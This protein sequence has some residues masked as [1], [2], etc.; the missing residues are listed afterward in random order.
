MASLNFCDRVFQAIDDGNAKEL[1]KMRK[2]KEHTEIVNCLIQFNTDG[3][4]PL[5]LAIRKRNFDV[6]ESLIKSL[7]KYAKEESSSRLLCLSVI[8]QVINS[9]IPI[10]EKMEYLIGTE[11]NHLSWV[12]FVSDSV[13]NSSINRLEKIAALEL[14]GVAYVTLNRRD[15]QYY[16]G[17]QRG[18]ECWKQAM[19]LRH[20]AVDPII[21][22]ILNVQSADYVQKAF[23]GAVLVTT[24]EELEKMPKYLKICRRDCQVTI[25]AIL[26][27]LVNF[28]QLNP[29]QAAPYYLLQY[30]RSCCDPQSYSRAISTALLIIEQSKWCNPI[31]SSSRIFKIVIQSLELVATCFD[32]LRAEPRNSPEREEF[33][34]T[35]FLSTVKFFLL[36]E[37]LTRLPKFIHLK[38]MQRILMKNLFDYLLSS[39]IEWNPQLNQKETLQLKNYLTHCQQFRLYKIRKLYDLNYPYLSLL[40]LAVSRLTYQPRYYF[41]R[42]SPSYFRGCTDWDESFTKTKILRLVLETGADPNATDSSGRIPL[43]FVAANFMECKH[44]CRKSYWMFFQTLLDAGSNLYLAKSDG[45]TVLDVLR[46]R[47]FQRCG[48]PYYIDPDAIPVPPLRLSYLCARVIR[49]H[50]IPVEDQLPP[51]L[52]RFVQHDSTFLGNLIILPS[53]LM[54]LSEKF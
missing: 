32:V 12:D 33:S 7:K 40:H 52:Q 50:Q 26:I 39:Y 19:N 36:T 41:N 30:L 9:K 8:N 34:S 47:L 4:T 51:I 14:I 1:S 43:H 5:Q 42:F 45:E 2:N 29:R 24:L 15:I 10:V 17:C 28:S 38:Y 23:G 25:Q 21:P 31:S 48:S 18:L 53:F 6:I 37:K 16:L 27:S 20:S 35:N 11:G 13:N 49:Y 54:H 3:D 46:R 22:K 44:F